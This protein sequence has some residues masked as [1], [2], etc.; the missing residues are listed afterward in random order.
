[1]SH[2]DAVFWVGSIVTYV[3]VLQFDGCVDS[4]KIKTS[5]LAYEQTDASQECWNGLCAEHVL[6]VCC[7]SVSRVVGWVIFFVRLPL[8]LRSYG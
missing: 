8:Q 7:V 4:G 2:K 6:H 5:C 3:K 1:M